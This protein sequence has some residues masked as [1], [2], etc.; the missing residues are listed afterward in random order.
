MIEARFD[1]V[2]IGTAS[3]VSAAFVERESKGE[4]E[5][6]LLTDVDTVVAADD[7]GSDHS[8]LLPRKFDKAEEE[9]VTRVDG[10]E[11]SYP[12]G[13]ENGRPGDGDG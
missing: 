1:C 13:C 5:G 9:A 6:V 8:P 7:A 10:L 11:A 2:R 3:L 12:R 4:E